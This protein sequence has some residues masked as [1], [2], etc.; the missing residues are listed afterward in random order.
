MELGI[1]RTLRLDLVVMSPTFMAAS[2]EG[3]RADAERELAATLPDGWPEG[4]E[5]FLRIRLDD[6]AED[7][8]VS[9][10]LIRAAVLREPAR[11]MVGHIGFRQVGTQINE[12]DGEEIVFER[13]ST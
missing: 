13:A 5:R 10:W 8:S 12:E 4:A 3:R 11:V 6:L 9:T 7:P 1:V 2:L